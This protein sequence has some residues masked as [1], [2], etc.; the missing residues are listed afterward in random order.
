M[1]LPTDIQILEKIYKAHKNDF[2]QYENDNSIRDN[3]IFVRVDL[4]KIAQEL[5]VDKDIVFGRLYYHLNH[6]FNYQNAG[7]S[8][9]KLFIN[10]GDY[11]K[12]EKG[13]E[14]N[15]PY[16]TSILAGMQYERR[17]YQ[18]ATIIAIISLAVSTISVTI[19]VFL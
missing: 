10:R 11:G 1:K 5:K 9:V 4:L 13:H 12:D 3:K 7:N 15:F 19:S 8:H 17:K 16:M 2:E 14:I 6:K 18:M